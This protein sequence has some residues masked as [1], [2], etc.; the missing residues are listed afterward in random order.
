MKAYLASQ[1]FA[2]CWRDYNEKVV[3]RILGAY[4]DLDLYVPQMNKAINDKTK[5]ATAE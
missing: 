3:D 1:I 4:P 5:C 2:E